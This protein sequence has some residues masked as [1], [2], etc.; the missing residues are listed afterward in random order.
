MAV[1][2]KFTFATSFDPPVASPCAPAAAAAEAAPPSHTDSDLA[3]ARARSFAEGRE[4]GLREASTTT[5]QRATVALDGI[6]R[7]I[8]DIAATQSRALDAYRDDAVRLVQT[9]ARKV[10]PALASRE[11]IRDIEALVRDCLSRLVEEPRIVIRVN[12]ALLDQVRSPMMDIAG[13]C[14]FAGQ[15]IFLGAPELDM[16]DCRIE[17]SDGGAERDMAGTWREVEEA[18]DRY[19]SRPESTVRSAPGSSQGDVKE[20][21]ANG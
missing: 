4:T 18:M 9:I 5:Q 19:L 1:A 10:I 6:S 21:T 20:N 2:R 8:A 13:Q 17:W 11:P 7:R 14:G 15:I 16:P 3:E 12:D